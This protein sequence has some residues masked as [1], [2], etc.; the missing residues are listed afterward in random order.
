VPHVH[1]GALTLCALVWAVPGRR[2][3][4]RAYEDEVLALLPDHGGS[5]LARHHRTI[6]PIDPVDPVDETNDEPDEVHLLVLPSHAALEAFRRDPRRRAL[7][8]R[9]DATLARSQV[10]AVDSSTPR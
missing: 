2:D 6:D 4:L 3:E 1:D 5:V 9:R 10:F 8:L 7:D